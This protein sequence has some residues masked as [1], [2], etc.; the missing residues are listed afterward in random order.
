MKNLKAVLAALAISAFV[1]N[2]QAQDRPKLTD[3]QRQEMKAQFEE[4]KKR[5]ALTPEQEKSFKE[6]HQKYAPEMKSVRKSESDKSDKRQ[7]MK[8][9]R[10]RKDADI[11]AILSEQQ[12]KTYLEMQ[13][14]RH[15]KMRDKRKENK[16]KE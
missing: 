8:D 12:Y 5:L 6:I 1:T 15:Q 10:E 3:E 13:K 14:E 9:L 2:V 7:K 4:S 11:K 16:S